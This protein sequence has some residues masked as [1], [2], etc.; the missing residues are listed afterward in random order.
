MPC[1]GFVTRFAARLVAALAVVATLPAARRLAATAAGAFAA[2][3]LTRALALLGCIAVDF[4]VAFGAR[5]A[6][7]D[8]LFDRGHRLLVERRHDRDCGAG[9]AGAAGAADAVDVIV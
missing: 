3:L 1:L 5:N 6:L 4:K 7:A 2:A 9:A 8:Q